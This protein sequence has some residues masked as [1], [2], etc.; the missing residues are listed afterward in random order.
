[1]DHHV[2]NARKYNLRRRSIQTPRPIPSTVPHG[3]PLGILFTSYAAARTRVYQRR[4]LFIIAGEGLEADH[5][6]T[7][8]GAG[9]YEYFVRSSEEEFADG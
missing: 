4:H 2:N 7:E 6:G 5:D 8:F 3:T 9:D 1:M